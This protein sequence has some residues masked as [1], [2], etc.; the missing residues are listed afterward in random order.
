MR[1]TFKNIAQTLLLNSIIFAGGGGQ[2][3]LRAEALQEAKIAVTG[4]VSDADSPGIGAGVTKKGIPGNGVAT[5]IAGKY[6]P[7]VSPS[8]TIAVANST[9]NF[10]LSEDDANLDQVVVVG[11]G[12]LKNVLI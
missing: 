11:Y 5:D 9:I 1:R 8:A 6:S 3:S 4:V 10:T 2:T 12:M 7:Q